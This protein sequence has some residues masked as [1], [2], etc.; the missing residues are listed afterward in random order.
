MEGKRVYEVWKAFREL[1]LGLYLSSGGYYY[2]GEVDRFGYCGELLGVWRGFSEFCMGLRWL[3]G[4]FR[5]L[6]LVLLYGDRF[7]KVVRVGGRYME[8]G[9]HRVG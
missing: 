5:R 8:G 2:L 3:D 6:G 1:G 7:L 9:I 4:E